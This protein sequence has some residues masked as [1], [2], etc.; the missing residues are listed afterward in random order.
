MQAKIIKFDDDNI[1]EYFCGFYL[2][3]F[4]VYLSLK[5]PFQSNPFQCS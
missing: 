3:T 5:F 2:F 4:Y 1:N